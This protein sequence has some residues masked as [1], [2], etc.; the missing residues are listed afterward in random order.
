MAEHIQVHGFLRTY[1]YWHHPGERYDH[2]PSVIDPLAHDD[3]PDDEAH[4]E[5]DLE[6]G[7]IRLLQDL[8]PYASKVY[9]FAGKTPFA[10]LLKDA[11]RKLDPDSS[12]SMFKLIVS[13]LCGKA[14][15]K[16]TN[17][18]FDFPL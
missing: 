5:N 10:Q 4:L 7:G 13:L 11:M 9:D 2:Q 16:I 17:S 14:F 3:P 15:G 1:I 6:D 12:S 8:Y 18:A